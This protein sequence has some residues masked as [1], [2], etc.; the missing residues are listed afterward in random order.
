MST[1]LC[2]L[3]AKRA[4]ELFRSKALSPVEL[5]SAII[6]R[7]EQI[8]PQ[9]NALPIRYFQEATAL[10]RHYEHAYLKGARL[11]A[12]AGLPIAIKDE[13]RIAGRQTP[14]GSLLFLDHVPEVTD[15]VPERLMAEG[16]I[17]HARSAA[18]EFSLSP[19]TMSKLWG[20]TRNP[21]NT[22]YTCGGSSGG[23]GAALAAGT[24][25]LANGTD[26]GGSIRVPASQNGVVGYKPS[27]GRIPYGVPLNLNPYVQHGCLARSV[28]DCILIANTLIGPHPADMTSLTPKLDIP[29]TFSGLKNSRVAYSMGFAY[30]DLEVSVRDNT[31]NALRTFESLGCSITEVNLPWGSE[32]TK[33][34]LDYVAFTI[35]TWLK[36][37]IDLGR[38]IDKLTPYARAF[39]ERSDRVGA[40]EL[41]QANL[42]A[43]EM[44]KQLMRVFEKCDV[45]I[46][47]TV[48]TPSVKAE[49]DPAVDVVEINGRNL[50]KG[51]SWYL[52][53][54]FNMLNR[55]PVL[56]VPSG[57]D[58]NSIPTGI[59]IVGRPYD[60]VSVFRFGSCYEDAFP[61]FYSKRELPLLP[62][63]KVEGGCE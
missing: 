32:C 52:T 59:Q 50:D 12:L 35:G 3:P 7:A 25:M 6:A 34:T 14:N 15:P 41:L 22:R 26:V 28:S 10:A 39:L 27:R 46:C 54:P 37:Q 9:I 30:G 45:L 20:V 4:I 60:D 42:L 33:A 55:C 13:T 11:G 17:V 57:R 49:H 56:N 62:S 47:P 2:Y 58:K 23:A 40:K 36:S 16:G 5:L 8:E 61:D 53:H 63:Q 44:Y 18:P 19:T 48:R 31:I 43:S 21:W 29:E 24:T 38:D 51:T 1:E